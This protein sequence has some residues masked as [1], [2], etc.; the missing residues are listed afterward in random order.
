MVNNSHEAEAIES[1]LL[2]Y[3]ALYSSVFNVYSILC[4]IFYQI[5]KLS[6]FMLARIYCTANNIEFLVVIYCNISNF[7]TVFE[8]TGNRELLCI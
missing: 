5:L 1:F 3:I 2:S 6:E 4:N 8:R 7:A